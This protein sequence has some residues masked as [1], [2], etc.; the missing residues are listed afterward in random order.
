[1]DLMVCNLDS[2]LKLCVICQKA[3]ENCEREG[4]HIFDCIG[5]SWAVVDTDHNQPISF[6]TTQREATTALNRY[7]RG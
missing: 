6:H 5:Y 3:E 4:P 7:N 2:P 1:M